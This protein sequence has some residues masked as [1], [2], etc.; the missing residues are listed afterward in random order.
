MNMIVNALVRRLENMWPGYFPEAKHKHYQ[1]FGYPVSVTFGMLHDMYRRNGL[2][3][4][5]V[6]KLAGKTWQSNPLLLEEEGGDRD[7]P[8]VQDVKTRFKKLRL[9]QLCTEADRRS[10]VGRYAGLI[11]RLADDKDFDQPVDTVPGG[12]EG[13]VELIP[14]WE[15]QLGVAEWNTDP[16]SEHYGR[17]SMFEFNEAAVTPADGDNVARTLARSIHPDRV[18]LFSEDGTVHGASSLEAGYN[19]LIDIEKIKGAGGEGFWR[20]A[21][22]APVLSMD[23]DADLRRMALSMGVPEEDLVDTLND[24]VEG[25]QKGFDKMLLLQGITPDSMSIQLADPKEFFSNSLQSFAASVD[26]PLKILVGMQTGERASSEDIR[27][28][29]STCMARREARIVPLLYAL[30]DRLERFGI[31]PERDWFLSWEDLREVG[32]EEKIAR[33]EKM[34]S[35]NQ[36]MEKTGE[37]IF[38][39]EEIREAV[40]MAPLADADR[41]LDQDP[42]EE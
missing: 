7:A 18:L 5:A 4:A 33:A 42:E 25:W 35:V 17:P 26:I 9:W 3:K 23:K 41:F 10:I 21:K 30:V 29:N 37:I 34:A 13:L 12:L 14:A 32:M 28:F 16:Q 15:G 11:L 36:K 1:D 2:A 24:H 39:S 20:N 38:L 22:Q 6:N 31:L 19:D 8:L 27:E 40:G